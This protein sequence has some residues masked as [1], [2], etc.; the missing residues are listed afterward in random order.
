ML[1]KDFK[2]NQGLRFPDEFLE[3]LPDYCLDER[4]GSPTEMSETLTGLH[5]SN[6]RCPTKVAKRI[7]TI[8]TTLGVKD[9]GMSR[10]NDFVSK[11]GIGNPLLIFAYEPVDGELGCSISMDMSQKIYDQFATKRNFTLWEYVRIANLPYIQSSA[12][13][14][15]GDY[16]DLTKAYEDIEAGGVDFIQRKLSIT[17]GM[18]KQSAA[19][20]YETEEEITDVSIRAL[21]VYQ[22]LMMF[23]A[24]LF[25]ALPFVNIIE[26]HKEGVKT[27]KAVCSE[28]V[29]DP[30]RTKSEFYAAVNGMFSDIHVE[31]LQAVNKGIDYLIWA[32]AEDASTR[33]TNKVKKVRAWNSAYFE[34]KTSGSLREGQHEI[35]IVSASQFIQILKGISNQ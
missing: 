29:G 6:P 18:P 25:Q 21:K 9:L 33:V 32:G 31:F 13:H 4:C 14:I 15:F 2:Q 27:L 26:T 10:A 28:Q 1:V 5:C 22:S 35:P 11:F 8:A 12:L 3:C 20:I 30:Y 19:E 24:D 7:T 16:D 17:K 34:D 23:K